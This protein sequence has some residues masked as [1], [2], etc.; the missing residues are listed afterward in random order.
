MKECRCCKVT[1]N[2]DFFYK[3]LI[4]LDGLYSYCKECTLRKNKVKTEEQKNSQ[5]EKNNQ[6]R[7]DRRSLLTEKSKQYYHK[8]REKC[9]ETVKKYRERNKKNISIKESKKRLSDPNRFEKNNLRHYEWAKKNREKINEYQ[10]NWYQRNK[11][12]R[13]AH[14]LLNRAIKLG[15]MMRPDFCSECLEKCKPDGHH[16]DYSLP[17]NVVWICRK[18]HSRKSPRTVEI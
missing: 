4:N 5:R 13:R 15:K 2:S 12:K 3:N 7:C 9:L 16:V 18:C 6:Y 14:V 8:N 1:K 11:E 10:R 17:L